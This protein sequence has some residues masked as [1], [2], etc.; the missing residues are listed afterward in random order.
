MQQW[1]LPHLGDWQDARRIGSS[2]AIKRLVAAG[3]GISCLSYWVVSDALLDGKLKRLQHR[4]APHRR[5]L[6]IVHHR[7]KFI[8][9]ALEVFLQA[10][11]AFGAAQTG[12]LPG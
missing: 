4:F 9:R 11:Q 7:D 6:H 1:L 8:S 2:E 12:S 3:V 5:Q 10:V